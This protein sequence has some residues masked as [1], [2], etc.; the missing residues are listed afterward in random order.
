MGGREGARGYLI[1]TLIALLESLQDPNWTEVSIE[2]D[3]LHEKVDVVWHSK[4]R[5]KVVQVKSSERQ[6]AKA[7]AHLWASE[8]RASVKATIYSLILVG[9]CSDSVTKIASFDGVDIPIPRPLNLESLLAE[10][11]H[12]LDQYLAAIGRPRYSPKQREIIVGTLATRLS[13]MS[14]ES[15][16]LS[17]NSFDSLLEFW[18]NEFKPNAPSV[19]SRVDF[20]RQRDLVSALSGKRLGP[21]DVDA[22]PKLTLCEDVLKELKRSHSHTIVG[23]AGCGKSITLWQVAKSLS[24]EGFKVWRPSDG[25]EWSKLVE[26]LPS[27][28]LN[29]II[30]DDAH[31]APLVVRNRLVEQSMA[32]C[33]VLFAMTIDSSLHEEAICVNALASVE[34][35]RKAVLNRRDEFLPLIQSYDND[36]GD[37]ARDVSLEDRLAHAADQSTPWLFFWVLRGGWKTAR[38][39]HK[40]LKQFHFAM[41]VIE[42]IACFQFATCDAGVPL[43]RLEEWAISSGIKKQELSDAIAHLANRNLILIDSTIRTKHLA[44]AGELLRMSLTSIERTRW[45]SLLKLFTSIMLDEDTSLKGI[46]WLRGTLSASDFS[47]VHSDTLDGKVRKHIL[48]RCEAETANYGW[49]AACYSGVVEFFEQDRVERDRQKSL[50]KRWI[51]EG[52]EIAVYFCSQI[53]NSLINESDPEKHQIRREELCDFVTELDV[54]QLIRRANCLRLDDF[55]SFGFLL[56]RLAFF[57]PPWTEKFFSE[58]DWSRLASIANSAEAKDSYAVNELVMGFASLTLDFESESAMN[59]VL[60]VQSF[61][62]RAINENP[63]RAMLSMDD[64][65]WSCLGLPPK[66]FRRGEGPSEKQLGVARMCLKNVEPERFRIS[67]ERATPRQMENIAKSIAAI[68]EIRPDFAR[69]VVANLDKKAFLVNSKIAWQKQSDELLHLLLTLYDHE[70]DFEPCKG[71]IV[72]MEE[73]IEGPLLPEL[74]LLSPG[75]AIRFF[76]LQK[77]IK[78]TSRFHVRWNTTSL[79]IWRIACCDKEKAARIVSTHFEEL[80]LALYSLTLDEPKYIV[81]FF[82]VLFEVE[83]SIYHGFI[84]RIDLHH[85]LAQETIAK[86]RNN[87]P[88]ERLSFQK[89]ARLGLRQTGKIKV[90][91]KQLLDSLQK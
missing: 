40:D 77:P 49:A 38:R 44:Y 58:V 83:E 84:E 34:E 21:N 27:I 33:K 14:A 4:E 63:S 89:L 65:F 52:D 50:I 91:S 87:Q 3:N 32:E 60:S 18:L 8:L 64:I 17:R 56:N 67:I 72:E 59:F 47:R 46:H 79:A 73:L 31:L 13:E 9:P 82:R 43:S 71:W 6:I 75:T 85:A 29:L 23:T 35:L 51:K 69:S 42:A 10:A 24:D 54:D 80:L 53:F 66:M 25:A 19:W 55:S 61:I 11:A 76:E 22:C 45:P 16:T 41:D 62:T 28:G 90:I 15:G 7:D 30:V 81:R 2:P 5:T 70:A 20:G 74:A 48:T 57:R 39:E 12:R 26:D 86:L 1:Q 68:T 88:R 37:F 78:L 36:V